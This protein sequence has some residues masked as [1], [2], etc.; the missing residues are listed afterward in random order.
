MYAKPTGVVALLAIACATI[1]CD[2]SCEDLCDREEELGCPVADCR[3]ECTTQD[4]LTDASGCVDQYDTKLS[5]RDDLSDDDFCT[6]LDACRSE[7]VAFDQCI[8]AYCATNPSS[9][10]CP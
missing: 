10:G 8:K 5:C 4:N 7:E 9:T 2:V 3:G 6:N 1:S